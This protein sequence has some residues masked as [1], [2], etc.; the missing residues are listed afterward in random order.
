M[1]GVLGKVVMCSIHW[2]ESVRFYLLNLTTLMRWI[3]HDMAST[4]GIPPIKLRSD[5]LNHLHGPHKSHFALRILLAFRD[6]S[7]TE[8]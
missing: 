6:S 2:I 1:Q 4:L 7:N 3:S 8:P 5:R